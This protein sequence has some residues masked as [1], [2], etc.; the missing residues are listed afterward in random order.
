MAR[1]YKITLP[2]II[3]VEADTAVEA[4][5]ESDK[6]IMAIRANLPTG[7]VA[8]ARRFNVA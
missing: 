3:S 6:I 1:T 2:I 5:R 7:A 8:G 4:R